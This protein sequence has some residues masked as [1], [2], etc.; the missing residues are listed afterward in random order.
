MEW[1][2][3]HSELENMQ[4]RNNHCLMQ[5]TVLTFSL[6]D[7]GKTWKSS[8]LQRKCQHVVNNLR[9]STNE[10]ELH[11]IYVPFHGQIMLVHFM[12]AYILK[13]LVACAVTRLIVHFNNCTQL[14]T[15]MLLYQ[16]I[17]RISTFLYIYHW[18]CC[19]LWRC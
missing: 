9:R 6:K 7:W 14:S 11:S 17:W 18:N 15:P 10:Q 8:I 3:M 4:K 19:D 12:T 2:L 16:S 5:G 13:L 1:W